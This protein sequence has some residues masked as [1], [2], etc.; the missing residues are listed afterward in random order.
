VSQEHGD[1]LA[2]ELDELVAVVAACREAAAADLPTLETN[3]A[4]ARA[5]LEREAHAQATALT[6]RPGR[7]CSPRHRMPFDSIK[8]TGTLIHRYTGT[9]VHW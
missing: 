6:V 1:R 8:Y 2:D 3:G 5:G 7:H 9:L 4:R